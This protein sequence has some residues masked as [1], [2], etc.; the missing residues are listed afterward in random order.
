MRYSD[1]AFQGYPQILT[2]LAAHLYESLQASCSSQLVHEPSFSWRYDPDDKY[3]CVRSLADPDAPHLTIW[4]PGADRPASDDS[5]RAAQ[6]AG[7]YTHAL[8][9]DTQWA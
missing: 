2:Q 1:K 3:T 6:V 8:D 9:R 7:L 5:Y 4:E